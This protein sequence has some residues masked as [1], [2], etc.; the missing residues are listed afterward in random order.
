MDKLLNWLFNLLKSK[1]PKLAAIVLLAVGTLHYFIANGGADY[2]G[3]VGA[4]I[5]EVVTIVW[6]ALQ[7]AVTTLDQA[8]PKPDDN[9][10]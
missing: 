10:G 6:L 4:K 9:E 2:L 7:G 1:D 3:E 8:K 5:M